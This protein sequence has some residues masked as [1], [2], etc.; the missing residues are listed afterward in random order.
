M[1]QA[2]LMA[3]EA[4]DR[5]IGPVWVEGEISGFKRHHPSGH[6]YF[7]LK[8]G[9]SR[10]SCV[11]WRDSA[12]RLR[13]EPL[14]GVLVRAHG[15]LGIY[16]VQGKLQLYVDALEPAGLGALQAALEKLKGRLAA[17]GLFDPGR[18]RSLPAFPMK[19][20]LATSSTGAAIKDMLRVL[21]ERWPVAEVVLRPCQVQGDGAAATIVAA[22]RD[23][24]SVP[25]LDLIILGRGGGSIEDLWCF[26]DE[27]VVRA[28]AESRVPVV[29]GIGHE[30]DVTL[31]DFAADV[32]A[33]TPS[34]AAE[35][36]V[37]SRIEVRDRLSAA[38]ARS[39]HRTAER[40]RFL[41]MRL[42]RIEDSHGLKRP[43]DLVRQ[44]ML[45]IDDLD[46]HLRKEI[47]RIIRAERGRL[48]LVAHRFAAREPRVR[49]R[50]D[51]A[52]LEALAERLGRAGLR[53]IA[54]EKERLRARG[55]H[56]DAVGPRSVLGRGYAICMRDGR[57]VRSH[58]QVA[59]GQEVEVLLHEGALDCIVKDARGGRR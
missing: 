3:K 37:P 1:T 12:R 24:Q 50:A 26:N 11:Q 34:Q 9:R 13:F 55:A 44:R 36:A 39:A 15:R 45:R 48:D 8:D 40:L 14:D 33:A 4:I 31:A 25:E 30:I 20:G 42:R 53:R 5:S 58:N 2:L 19:I 49:L 28:V 21:N 43:Q 16:E 57:A 27:A 52:R 6:L 10:I 17:E 46:L 56:L 22:L 47:R 54:G 7:E 35:L 38:S 32:R 51:R 23:L 41:R 18:K 29:S 59:P